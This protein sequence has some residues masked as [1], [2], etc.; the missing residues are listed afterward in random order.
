VISA[1]TEDPSALRQLPVTDPA[2]R[3][4]IAGLFATQLT[5]AQ[6]ERYLFDFGGNTSFLWGLGLLRSRRAI[7]REQLAAEQAAKLELI[8][9]LAPSATRP[10]L[11]QRLAEA[12]AQL[13]PTLQPR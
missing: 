3:A 12:R 10:V 5:P 9:A 6:R 1:I 7:D 11:Q 8:D 4:H 2:M 13:L